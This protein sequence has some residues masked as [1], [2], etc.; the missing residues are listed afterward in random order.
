M[1]YKLLS[2]DDQDEIL[3]AHLAAVERDHYCHGLNVDRYGEMLKV[4]PAVDPAEAQKPLQDTDSF[5]LRI[6]KLQ[7]TEQA[8]KDQA[9]LILVKL[10]AQL[11]SLPRTQAA[12]ARNLAKQ[13]GK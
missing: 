3:A 12:H 10:T 4:L 11:P 9:E 13:T 6:A 7:R 8:A 5:A 1:A 2:Q